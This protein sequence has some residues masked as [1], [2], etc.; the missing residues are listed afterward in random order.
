[1]GTPLLAALPG[2]V[3]RERSLSQAL[4]KRLPT[5]KLSVQITVAASRSSR[6]YRAV[7][8]VAAVRSA[9]LNGNGHHIPHGIM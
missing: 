5:P 2:I 1:M 3:A 8:R 6:S 9:H 7:S 4:I